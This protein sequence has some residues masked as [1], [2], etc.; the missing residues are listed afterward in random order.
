MPDVYLSAYPMFYKGG[1]GLKIGQSGQFLIKRKDF[2]IIPDFLLFSL[3][4]PKIQLILF[5]LISAF[6]RLQSVQQ[7]SSHASF[8]NVSDALQFNQSKR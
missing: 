2:C 4:Y 7:L 6:G 8:N 1:N 5:Q 3:V